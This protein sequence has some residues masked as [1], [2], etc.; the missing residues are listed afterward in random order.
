M[1]RSTVRFLVGRILQ[2]EALL[3]LFPLIVSFIYRESARQMA[4]YAGTIVILL[5]VSVICFFRAPKQMKIMAR[6]SIVTVALSWIL[7]SFFGALPFVFSGEIPNLADAFFEVSSGFTTTGSSILPDLSILAHSSLFWRSFTHLI[8]GMGVLVFAL[9]ILPSTGS[10][11][12]QLMRAEVPGPVFGKL[13]SKLT[14]T[15]QILYAIYLAMTAVLVLILVITGVPLFDSLLLSFGTAGTGGFAINNA[16][17]TIY[18]HPAAVEWIIGVGMMVFGINFNLYYFLLVGQVKE[19]LH[20]EEAKSYIAIIVA[21][22]AAIFVS[23]TIWQANLGVSLRSVFFTV[24]SVITTT[25]YSTADFGQWGLLPQMLLLFLMFVGGSAGST[26]GGLKVSRVVIYFK[27]AIAEIK[28]M[29][30]PRRVVVSKFNG[31]AIDKKTESSVLN[32]LVVYIFVF[33]LI[34]LSIS[35]EAPDFLT[36]FS[37]V[38]ATFNNIGPGL[39]AVGP[40]SNFSMYSNWNKI[41]LSIGMIAG[42]LEIYPIILLF[43]TTS[44]RAFFRRERG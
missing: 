13:V 26:S 38:A 22:T 33:L 2:V 12:V 6:D 44:L 9:A 17:F 32:Y 41:V 29:G 36:A 43:S 10:D 18:P 3:L 27:N 37:S 40:T 25:G 19:V 16:G 5:V 23:L 34:L 20:D 42:R 39:G 30:Q 28:K 21:T 4:S 14:K 1:R 24:S 7:L 11:S 31:K 35:F 8:G 15:A